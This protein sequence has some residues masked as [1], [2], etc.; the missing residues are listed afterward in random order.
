MVALRFAIFNT[1]L[2]KP[3]IFIKHRSKRKP[4][5]GGPSFMQKSGFTVVD[6]PG[7]AMKAS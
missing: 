7:Q 4:V 2:A 3:V 1:S 5:R 6:R